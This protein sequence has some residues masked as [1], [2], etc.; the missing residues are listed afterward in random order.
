V[1]RRLHPSDS[2]LDYRGDTFNI[3]MPNALIVTLRHSFNFLVYMYNVRTAK[4]IPIG[5]ILQVTKPSV[6]HNV[7]RLRCHDLRGLPSTNT[8]VHILLR[9]VALQAN[10]SLPPATKDGILLTLCRVR[11]SWSLRYIITNP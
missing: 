8:V 4:S 11:G 5:R 2:T 10:L 7:H 1:D 3:G 9:E 6:G